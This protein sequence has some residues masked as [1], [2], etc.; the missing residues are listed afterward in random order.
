MTLAF[1]PLFKERKDGLQSNVKIF[2]DDTSLFSVIF[3]I[4]SSSNILNN[5]LALISDWA[6]QWKMSF[7]PDPS[8]QA[9]EVAFSSKSINTQLPSLTFNGSTINPIESHKHLGMILDK[10]LSFNHHIKEKISKANKGIGMINRLYDYLPRHTLVNIYKAFVRPHLDYGDIIYDNPCNE[11][12]CSKIE[13][14]QYNAALAITRAIR[15]TSRE[16]L[17]HELGFEH[18]TGRRYCRRL[19]FFYKINNNYTASYLKNI[20]PKTNLSSHILRSNRAFEI[21]SASTE[22]FQSSFFPYC[23]AKWNALEPN[24]QNAPSLQSFKRHFLLFFRPVASPV[25]NLNNPYGLKLLT[26]LRLGLSHLREHKFRR[27]FH[28]TID[29]YCTC[30]IG[31]IESVEHFFL[32]C[33]NYCSLRRILFD[34]LN[35]NGISILPYS[36]PFLI[37]LLLYGNEI[38]DKTSNKNILSF[39][40]NFIIQSKRFDGP[41]L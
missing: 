23:V 3:D 14:V 1:A 19:C 18:L 27:N 24:I 20:L 38:Y 37:Q 35:L 5:D 30:L 10:K 21:P 22:R 8:K 29:P 26:R 28:N 36:S 15:G 25:Y 4:L 40:I 7:N 12:F 9:A 41:L 6:F 17:Y 16:K 39:V 33:P 11:N 34:N 31:N 32:H 13:S 2:A